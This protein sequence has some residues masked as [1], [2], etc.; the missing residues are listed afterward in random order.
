MTHHR[1]RISKTMRILHILDH[2]LPIQS[3]YA[4]R[5]DAILREQA[6]L[7]FEIRAITGPKHDEGN[8]DREIVNGIEFQRAPAGTVLPK[9]PWGGYVDVIVQL[10]KRIR[11]AISDMNPDVIHAH[12]P[13]LNALA[14][15]G[16]NVPVVY[17]MRS[18]WEDAAVS[19]GTTVEGSV[20]YRLSQFL[21]TKVLRQADA[22]TTICEGLRG[23][24]I[25]RGVGPANVTVVPNAVRPEEFES[26]AASAPDER[27]RYKKLLGFFGSFFAWE[28]LPLLIRAVA[29]I[30]ERRDDV[31][32]I[33]AGGGQQEESLVALVKQL[34][35]SPHIT[36]KG[37]V[38]HNEIASLYQQVDVM[39]YPRE[40]MRLTEL[41]TPLKPLEAMATGCLVVAS[42]V[43]GHRELIRDGETG[44][45]FEAGDLDALIAT[46]ERVLALSDRADR[47]RQ[48]ALK[49]I[50][51][52]RTWPAV[53]QRYA[54]VY[55]GIEAKKLEASTES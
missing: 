14:A 17:E 22:V 40:R 21:E 54:T 29:N 5:S 36:F 48:R 12:S 7:G 34:G 30:V 16:L 27:F 9:L 46:L 41:V 26:D 18:F 6:K 8:E 13:C 49:F 47:V 52:E 39:V 1:T 11:D 31:H 42:N 32:L 35:V 53:A 20:R 15:F 3:G 43:G 44:F 4:F 19:N 24:I 37:R 51:S 55:R 25:K 2:S 23:E 45:L 38:S 33:L 10:R 50:A 28:G